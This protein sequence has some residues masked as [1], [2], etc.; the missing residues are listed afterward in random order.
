MLIAIKQGSLEMLKLIADTDRVQLYT[1]GAYA[2]EV[3]KTQI[4]LL[5][6]ALRAGEWPIVEYLILE[7]RFQQPR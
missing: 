6:T 3:A 4:T 2:I 1:Y 7:R 5:S